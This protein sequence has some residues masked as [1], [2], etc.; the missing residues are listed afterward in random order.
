[1]LVVR[2]AFFA[3]GAFVV[4]WTVMSAIRMVVMPRSSAGLLGRL[5]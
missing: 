4:A 5:I 3:V 2:V 1:M